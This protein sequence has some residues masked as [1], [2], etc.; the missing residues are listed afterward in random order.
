MSGDDLFVAQERV[1]S[2]AERLLANGGFASTAERQ[3]YEQ[4]LKSYQKLF[5][6]GRRLMTT[7][8]GS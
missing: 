5:R 1:I 2:A 7:M 4:L 3:H 8:S 6:T